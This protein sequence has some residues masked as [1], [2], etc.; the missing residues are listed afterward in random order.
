[1]TEG[2]K[3]AGG[4]RAENEQRRVTMKDVAKHAGVSQPTVSFVLN[5]RRDVSVAAET[6]ARVLESA[7]ILDF[8]P[9]R[10]AQALRSNNSYTIGIVASRLVSQP[11]AGQI[12][13]GVQ[14][15]VQPAGYACVVVEPSETAEAVGA[16]VRKLVSQ[17]VAGLIYAAPGPEPVP[18]ASAANDVRTLFVNCWSD[19]V[20]G[21]AQVFADEYQGGRDAAAATFAAGHRNVVYLGGPAGDY[22]CKER[23]RGLD[24]AARA[25]GIDPSSIPR[26]YGDYQI[27]SGYN[28]ALGVLTTEAPTAVI[29][30]ND[31]MAIG[32]LMAAHSAGLNCPDDVSI[33][34]FDDQPDIAAQLHPPLTTVALPH[35]Q[36]G[37][38]AG[39]LLLAEDEPE[40]LHLIPCTYIARGSLAVPRSR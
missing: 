15:S 17:G 23:V 39:E 8:Q 29:C 6:R 24:D 37:I 3:R 20:T 19:E 36:M 9:N 40:P 1:M 30:G 12:V 13:L 5:D 38:K 28:L 7:R 35:L 2:K 11:Y 32:A 33:V 18:A 31:R 10:A 25:A 27:G 16:A 21:D 26:L 14:Q 22:A 34:G 4:A